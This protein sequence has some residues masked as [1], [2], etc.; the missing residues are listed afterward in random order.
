LI[1]LITGALRGERSEV[2]GKGRKRSELNERP[3]EI[4]CAYILFSVPSQNRHMFSQVAY[5]EHVANLVSPLT[6]PVAVLVS[7]SNWRFVQLRFLSIS[8]DGLVSGNFLRN[9]FHE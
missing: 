3:R 2:S 6:G 8:F 7:I 4:S 1:W 5:D 9:Y